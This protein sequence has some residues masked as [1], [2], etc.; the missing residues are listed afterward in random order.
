MK[1]PRTNRSSLRGCQLLSWGTAGW[2]EAGQGA[3]RPWASTGGV[4]AENNPPDWEQNPVA[5]RAAAAPEREQVRVPV[6]RV[7]LVG[8]EAF[9]ERVIDYGSGCIVD[10]LSA[11][12]QLVP[13]CE[14]CGAQLTVNRRH[15]RHASHLRRVRRVRVMS[16][17]DASASF[18]SPESTHSKESF[19]CCPAL[20]FFTARSLSWAKRSVRSISDWECSVANTAP[21]S[22]MPELRAESARLIAARLELARRVQAVHRN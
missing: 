9:R 4:R 21:T 22:S 15:P 5:N 2:P 7:G 16:G 12:Q 19:S 8:L 18:G 1:K 6:P 11:V 10:V 13:A 3:L 14:R 17:A 20:C